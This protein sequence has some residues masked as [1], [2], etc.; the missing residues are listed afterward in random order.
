M[1]WTCG[2][3]QQL[4]TPSFFLEGHVLFRHIEPDMF[5]LILP[6]IWLQK[7][8]G[9]WFCLPKGTYVAPNDCS[10]DFFLVPIAASLGRSTS[11]C[12][13]Q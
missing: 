3:L 12:I 6:C 11:S 10:T 2:V 7:K 4:A 9:Q 13:L 5:A 1:P 8:N